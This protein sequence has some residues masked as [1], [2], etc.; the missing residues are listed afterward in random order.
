[1]RFLLFVC[2]YIS[3][4]ASCYEKKKFIALVIV[5]IISVIASLGPFVFSHLEIIDGKVIAVPS[6]GMALFTLNSVGLVA[7]GVYLLVRKFR[8]AS[9]SLKVQLQYI[10]LGSVIMN[11]LL[12]FFNFIIYN[13]FKIDTFLNLG[14]LFV[15]PFVILT[16]YAITRYRFMDIHVVV[17]KSM[18]YGGTL[19]CILSVFLFVTFWL[20]QKFNSPFVWILAILVVVFVQTPLRRKLKHVLDGVFFVDELDLYRQLHS[21][22]HRLEQT[23]ELKTL[24]REM[25]QSI[26]R[27]VPITRCQVFIRERDHYRY[28][29]ADGENV[30]FDDPVP[31][32]LRHSD[33]AILLLDELRERND[34]EALRFK[35]FLQKHHA[36]GMMRLG[37]ILGIVLI[38]TKSSSKPLTSQQLQQLE[39]VRIASTQ[40]LNQLFRW[41]DTMRAA[42]ARW[43]E[44]Q[45]EIVEVTTKRS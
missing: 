14:A 38:T 4:A 10:L 31:E 43:Q 5:S 17:K 9:G 34:A 7:L 23:H 3:L 30:A 2:A 35:K 20:V 44:Q 28:H 6:F 29:A 25:T 45:G 24:L 39:Y 19:V 8:N 36:S 37:N 42:H 41:H 13:I 27:I 26:R 21:S 18:I 40:A 11:S 33:S 15:F 32:I 16:A 1:M 12:I 22:M